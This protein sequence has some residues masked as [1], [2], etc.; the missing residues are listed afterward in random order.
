MVRQERE[1]VQ[2]PE[3]LTWATLRI[4]WPSGL[5]MLVLLLAFFAIIGS[6]A[7]AVEELP[8]YQSEIEED[9]HP[10]FYLGCSLEC[11]LTWSMSASSSLEPAGELTY[12]A[13]NVSDGRLDTCWAEGVPGN[14]I[15]QWIQFKIQDHPDRKT[16]APL[17]G[18][19]IINGYIKSTQL[20]QANSRVQQFRMELNEK[21]ICY[22]DLADTPKFQRV[23]FSHVM[24][25][26]GDRIR[27]VI[28]GVYPGNTYD[29][30][31]VTI[32]RPMGAH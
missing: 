20:W 15:G 7:K 11:A 14:G 27:L 31:C 29:D 1:A 10:G 16:E 26:A 30:T 8:T 23:Y 24:V 13:D 2:T 21:P 18:L 12:G 25:K 3:V 22:I 28:T 6:P 17:W 9:D 19:H 32:I 4:R 5:V